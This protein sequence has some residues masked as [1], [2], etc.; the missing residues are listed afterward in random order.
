MLA[1]YISKQLMQRI[2]VEVVA[3]SIMLVTALIIG[4]YIK[5]ILF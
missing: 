3:D 1:K 4:Y 2:V 5:I